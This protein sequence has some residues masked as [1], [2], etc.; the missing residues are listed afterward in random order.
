MNTTDDG[1]MNGPGT[2]SVFELLLHALQTYADREEVGR[3]EYQRM[4]DSCGDELVQFLTSLVAQDG[5]DHHDL[6][7]R[8]AASLGDAS[9]R[10]VERLPA[11]PSPAW[12]P[13]PY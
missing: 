3:L 2:L 6:L 12:Q 8:M 7:R 10:S 11:I 4:A 1:E 5:R 9:V 13:T